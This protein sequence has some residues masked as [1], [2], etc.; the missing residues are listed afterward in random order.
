MGTW[1][2][3]PFDNDSAADF[4]N[5]LHAAP[6][7]ERAALIR[8]VLT[9]AVDND[10]YLE[11]DEGAP[12]VAAA[13]LLACRLPGG[14]QFAPDGYSPAASVPGLA[15]DLVPPAISALDRVLAA[16]SELASLWSADMLPQRPWHTSMLQLKSVL[17]TATTDT[18]DP[19]CEAAP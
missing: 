13:A 18:T 3:G 15:A 6:E 4:A 9:A 19:R 1:D 17:L 11:L 10:S 5:A 12:A 14:G 7:H 16:N 2:S 8:T